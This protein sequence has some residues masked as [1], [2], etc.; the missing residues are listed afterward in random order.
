MRLF[1][2]APSWS[3]LIFVSFEIILL[4]LQQRRT[5]SLPSPLMLSRYVRQRLS[6]RLFSSVVQPRLYAS[7]AS[8]HLSLLVFLSALFDEALLH[9][10]CKPVCSKAVQFR[11]LFFLLIVDVRDRVPALPPLLACWNIS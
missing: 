1:F 11:F 6:I 10:V 8:P 9:L 4:V 5:L 7:S 2:P 3:H